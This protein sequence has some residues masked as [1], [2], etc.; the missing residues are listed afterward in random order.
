MRRAWLVWAGCVTVVASAC[1][2]GGNTGTDS[3]VDSAVDAYIGVDSGGVD[4]SSDAPPDGV[5]V[6][7]GGD[8]GFN[9]T[10]G[11]TALKSVCSNQASIIQTVVELGS[12]MQ[13]VTGNLIIHL[14]H[15]RLGSGA[16]GGI[17]HTVANKA[18]TTVGASTTASLDID[19][20]T[21]SAMWNEDDCEFYVSEFVDKNGNGTIDPGEPAGHAI[22]PLSCRAMGPT[23]IGIVLDCVAGAS[24]GEFTDPGACTCTLPTCNSDSKY[25]N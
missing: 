17:P 11:T 12:G 3:G 5:T 23:C 21:G 16:T 15:Y 14:N 1:S 4:V 2:S 24:C 18:S 22:V 9:P 10:C 13:D 6:T 8:G 25:C 7:D 19:M 20:C